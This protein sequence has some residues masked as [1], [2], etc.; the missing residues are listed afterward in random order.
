MFYLYLGYKWKQV[1]LTVAGGNSEG[2]QINQLTR[3]TGICIDDDQTVYIAD[4]H[5]QRIVAGEDGKGQQAN[6]LNDPRALSF[7]REGNLYVVDY[8]NHRIQKF[9]VD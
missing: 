6:Q 1:V 7:D 3:P 2:D 4:V 5:N 9:V 8:E